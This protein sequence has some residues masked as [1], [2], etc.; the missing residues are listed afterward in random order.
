M[1]DTVVL[2]VTDNNSSPVFDGHVTT[3]EEGVALEN[4]SRPST[5]SL[6]RTVSTYFSI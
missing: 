4:S 6:G 2:M 5:A 1:H 3:E